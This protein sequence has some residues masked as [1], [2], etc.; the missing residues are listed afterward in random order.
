M[1]LVTGATGTVGG[2]V[3]RQL[4]DAG[5]KVRALT[6]DPSR[7]RLGEDVEVVGGDLGDPAT[8]PS[9]VEG[10]D[11]V[12]LMSLGHYKL[13]YDANLAR[14][15]ARAGVAHIVALSSLGV[16]EADESGVDNPLA[17]WHRVGEEAVR[18]S[19][20]AWTILRPGGFMSNTLNWAPSI[21]ADGVAYGP[22]AE[23]AEAPIDPDDIA[24]L[25][26]RALTTDGHAGAVYPLTGP[27]ALTPAQQVAVLAEVLGKPLRFQEIP[28]E[29]QRQGM[30]RALP[31]ETVDGVLESYAQALASGTFRAHVLDTVETVLGRPARTFREFVT[32]HAASF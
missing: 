7:A 16:Q 2:R 10:V 31:P 26:V 11:Q 25:A 4:R 20:V 28:L 13:T 29:V 24:A 30:L 14:A 5:E 18:E 27:E 8:L 22:W 3:V 15:A 12:F 17:R 23:L 21:R 19:G 9:V 32:D 1:I 6:R